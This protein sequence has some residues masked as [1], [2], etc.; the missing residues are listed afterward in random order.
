MPS[1]KDK[2]DALLGSLSAV[3][4]KTAAT[5]TLFTTP[6]GK[7]TR[8]THVVIRDA[9]ASLAGGTS[10]SFTSW[11]QTVSLAN[12]I[13]ANTGFLVIAAVSGTQYTELAASTAF[14]LTVTT[15]STLAA[16]ASIDVFG[17]TT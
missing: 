4:M 9:S 16:T 3:D 12:L 14:Q 8:I 2:S 6:V 17:F 11:V 1:L 5:T 7:V 10:Y 15:G 13:T